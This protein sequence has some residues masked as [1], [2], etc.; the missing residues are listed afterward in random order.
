MLGAEDGG[1]VTGDDADADVAALLPAV[2]ALAR[3]IPLM[4][5][6]SHHRDGQAGHPLFSGFLTIAA[7][8]Y[9][10]A[11]AAAAAAVAPLQEGGS[12]VVGAWHPRSSQAVSEKIARNLAELMGFGGETGRS[13]EC[14]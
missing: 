12:V 6:Q 10:A 4:Q 2:R 5:V 11:V 7:T 1:G 13:G 14:V 8:D 3:L 9:Y